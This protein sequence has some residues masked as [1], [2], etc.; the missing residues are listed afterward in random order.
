LAAFFKTDGERFGVLA[1]EVHAAHGGETMEIILPSD[2]EK[3]VSKAMEQA[4]C[5]TDRAI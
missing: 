4:V 5:P 3:T 2:E 1:L